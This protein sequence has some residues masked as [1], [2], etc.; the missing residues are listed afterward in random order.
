MNPDLSHIHRF[1]PGGEGVYPPLLL[2]HGTGGNENDLLSLGRMIAP[3]SALLSPRGK[4]LEN[5]MP[6]FFRRFAEGVFDMADLRLRTSELA[7]FIVAAG[8][9][10]GIDKPIALGYSNGANIAAAVLQLRPS[11][12]AGGI[13]LRAMLAIDDR[14]DNELSGKP[15]LVISGARDSIVPLDSAKSLARLLQDAGAVV[16]HQ[17]VPSGHELT[18]ADVRIAR[19]WLQMTVGN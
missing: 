18:E 10:Y 1:D 8:K 19:S 7:D 15:I 14:P 13:L 17:V 12:L 6:R 9:Q 3:H 5:G 11:V 4:V 2:L 16:D